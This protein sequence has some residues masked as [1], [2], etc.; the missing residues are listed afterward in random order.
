MKLLRRL[1]V[2]VPVIAGVGLAHAQTQIGAS[3]DR[4]LD[5]TT[6]QRAEIYLTIT[7]Q[8]PQA[9]DPAMRLSVGA[10]VP[11]ST[12]LYAM[13]DAVASSVP[14]TKIYKYLLVRNQVA[15]VDP[16]TMKVVDIL[17]Q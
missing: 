16:T 10:D 6:E 9:R 14:A 1:L 17:R 5:L 2:A 13:P 4:S 15:I 12:E 3:P 11:P 8:G 7:R